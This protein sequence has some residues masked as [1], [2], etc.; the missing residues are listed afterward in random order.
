MAFRRKTLLLNPVDQNTSQVQ[1]LRRHGTVKPIG[2]TL[3]FNNPSGIFNK[4][5]TNKEQV[6]SNLKNLL[7]TAKGERYFEPEFGT[8]IRTILFENIT[9]EEDFSSRLRGEIEGA[10]SRWLPYLV[11]TDINVNLN[12]NEDGRVDDPNH[13]VGIFLRVLIS[14]TNIYLPIRI[15]ISETATIRVIEEAQN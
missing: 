5:F 4:S 13:A 7:L 6:L 8:D 1:D 11:I 9:D 2:V 3:P 10:I 14:G 12:V 15:F